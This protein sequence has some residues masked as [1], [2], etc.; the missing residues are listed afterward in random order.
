MRSAVVVFIFPPYLLFI[1]ILH[2]YVGLVCSCST[3]WLQYKEHLFLGCLSSLLLLLLLP[4]VRTSDTKTTIFCFLHR[5]TNTCVS[6][7]HRCT[8]WRTVTSLCCHA[9]TP[10]SIAYEHKECVFGVFFLSKDIGWG[11]IIVLN[12]YFFM[13]CIV[14][15]HKTDNIFTYFNKIYI[16]FIAWHFYT[17]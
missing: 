15:S 1:F 11:K 9:F 7:S 14:I 8:W 5:F 13:V 17:I 10:Q 4:L 16:N 12:I 6:C 2:I 3:V